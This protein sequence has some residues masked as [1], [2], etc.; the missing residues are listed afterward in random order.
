MHMHTVRMMK[1]KTNEKL[2]IVCQSGNQSHNIEWRA[3]VQ[4]A[5]AM[6]MVL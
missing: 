6:A 3:I 2:R 1:L 4:M 5:E